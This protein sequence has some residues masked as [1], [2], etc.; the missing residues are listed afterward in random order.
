MDLWHRRLPRTPTRYGTATSPSR[1]FRR[2]CRCC[3]C[4]CRA[5]RRFAPRRARRPHGSGA[6]RGAAPTFGLAREYLALAAQLLHPAPPA[7]SPSVG[8]PARASPLWPLSLAPSAW[9]GARRARAPQRRDPEALGVC[10][11][12][13]PGRRVV[14]DLTCRRRSTSGS[15]SAL[16]SPRA[17][18]TPPSSTR[19][20]RG[21]AIVGYR[22]DG[23]GRVGPVHR[24]L[25]RRPRVH[26]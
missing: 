14:F 1:R 2:R 26:V 11:A 12:R 24:A 9:R 22:G 16:R 8:C 15:P 20:T 6:T 23:R 13:T 18:D 10:A 3:R 5:A 21:P 19:C 7:S 4:S 25:A 17:P